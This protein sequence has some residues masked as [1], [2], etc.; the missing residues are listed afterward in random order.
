MSSRG[1]QLIHLNYYNP[2]R[3]LLLVQFGFFDSNA[4]PWFMTISPSMYMG[5]GWAWVWYNYSWVGIGVVHPFIQLQIGVKLLGCRD[6]ANQEALQAEAK[7][8]NDLLFV[9]SNQNLV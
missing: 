3:S 2:K 7:I 9:Q 1:L 6:Y 5:F 4:I 8:V